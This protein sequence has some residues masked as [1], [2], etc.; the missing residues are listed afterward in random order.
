MIVLKQIAEEKFSDTGY[1]R[2]FIDEGAGSSLRMENRKPT[3]RI[4]NNNKS[5]VQAVNQL[6]CLHAFM[7]YS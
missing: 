2:P 5:S 1:T 6:N 7:L 3:G 4:S